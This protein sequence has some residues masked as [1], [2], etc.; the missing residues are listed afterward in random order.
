MQLFGDKA[1]AGAIV[2]LVSVLPTPPAG[3]KSEL[4]IHLL[5][6]VALVNPRPH[7]THM[8]SQSLFHRPRLTGSLC[9]L[10]LWTF[11]KSLKGLQIPNKQWLALVCPV[12]L[13]KWP[14]TWHKL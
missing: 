10:S 11:L 12:L 6:P 14:H 4:C 2:P 9:G 7:R 5:I 8:P 13:A 1:L 3:A